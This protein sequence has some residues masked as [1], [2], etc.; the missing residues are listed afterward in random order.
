MAFGRPGVNGQCDSCSAPRLSTSSPGRDRV[1]AS[2]PA[3]RRSAAPPRVADQQF[4]L[5]TWRYG[6][7]TSRRR[8]HISQCGALQSVGW[9][10]DAERLANQ[11]VTLQRLGHPRQ[12]IRLRKTIG[13]AANTASDDRLSVAFGWSARVV[14]HNRCS[15]HRSCRGPSSDA[16]RFQIILGRASPGGTRVNRPWTFAD[17]RVAG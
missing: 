13:S 4:G 6:G 16:W 2:P 9:C 7:Y 10:A 14:R 15:E 3:G 11:V 12:K 1:C 5:K 17:V 8:V